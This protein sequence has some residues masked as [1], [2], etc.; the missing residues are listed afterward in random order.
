MPPF[1]PWAFVHTNECEDQLL[2]G[3]LVYI[4]L[5][6]D[7]SHIGKRHDRFVFLIHFFRGKRDGCISDPLANRLGDRISDSDKRSPVIALSIAE[8]FG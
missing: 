1:T 5:F 4:F 2:T 7:C 8:T 3:N 6:K